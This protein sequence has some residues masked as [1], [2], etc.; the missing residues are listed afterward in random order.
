MENNPMPIVTEAELH[1]AHGFIY[2]GEVYKIQWLSFDGKYLAAE[3]V[4]VVTADKPAP[5]KP[6]YSDKVCCSCYAGFSGPGQF[7]EHCD[8]L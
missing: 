3:R 5:E 4:E 1:R 6:K 7:C 8:P 2:N